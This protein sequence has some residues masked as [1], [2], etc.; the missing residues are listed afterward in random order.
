MKFGQMVGSG[1]DI[2]RMVCWGYLDPLK[3]SLGASRGV[4][5]GPKM[6]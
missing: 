5:N 6:P 3:L 1:W 4:R 2:S